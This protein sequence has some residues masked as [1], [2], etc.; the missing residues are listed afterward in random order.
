MRTTI[1]ARSKC[2]C[3]QQ[4]RNKPP[5]TTCLQ[6][7]NSING[8][9]INVIVTRSPYMAVEDASHIITLQVL[10]FLN[11]LHLLIWSPKYILELVDL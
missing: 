10:S 4:A 2:K 3:K 9:R 1:S 7:D 11:S 8:K 6:R 5:K